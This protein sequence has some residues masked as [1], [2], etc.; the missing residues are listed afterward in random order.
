MKKGE[1]I[2]PVSNV[3]ILEHSGECAELR[4]MADIK[5]QKTGRIDAIS[6]SPG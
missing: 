4:V 2:D 5:T 6:K 1:G 3:Y